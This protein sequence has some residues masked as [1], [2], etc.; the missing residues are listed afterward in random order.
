[1]DMR[2]KEGRGLIVAGYICGILALIS[3]FIIP[4]LFT[5]LFIGW[6]IG[7]FGFGLAGIIIGI[8]NLVEGRMGHNKGRVGHGVAQIVI[9]ATPILLVLWFFIDLSICSFFGGD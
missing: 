5:L 8:V 1:M 6:S 2:N 9:A 4:R 3:W 7:V